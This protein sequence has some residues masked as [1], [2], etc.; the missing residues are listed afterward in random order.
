MYMY[1]WIP[2]SRGSKYESLPAHCCIIDTYVPPFTQSASSR[3][4]LS[5][6]PIS[7]TMKSCATPVSAPMCRHSW[8]PCATVHTERLQSELVE[9]YSYLGYPKIMCRSSLDT[10]VLPFLVTVAGASSIAGCEIVIWDCARG[11]ICDMKSDVRSDTSNVMCQK[12]SLA[13]STMEL[14]A[15]MYC[16]AHLE[17]S[18]IY[19]VAIQKANSWEL[20]KKSLTFVLQG[21]RAKTKVLGVL[22]RSL[23][24]Y[25]NKSKRTQ[26]YH[27]A[28]QLVQ[29]MVLQQNLY[30][31]QFRV[32]LDY[33]VA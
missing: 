16:R 8:H 28:V 1:L 30:E 26:I 20:V 17:R 22:T 25:S 14:C 12:S 24:V 5:A 10:H 23:G 4:W 2:K 15:F 31:C 13:K 18:S 32:R 6:A 27:L 21:A 7:A 19:L 29:Q 33:T 11:L 9:R 3:S